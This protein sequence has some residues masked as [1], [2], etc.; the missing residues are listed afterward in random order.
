MTMDV[1]NDTAAKNQ[2]VYLATRRGWTAERATESY[3]CGMLDCYQGIVD[4]IKTGQEPDLPLQ[5][6]EK[7]VQKYKDALATW[8]SLQGKPHGEDLQPSPP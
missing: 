2:I 7:E 4:A 8:R 3:L 5:E 6:A 1:L